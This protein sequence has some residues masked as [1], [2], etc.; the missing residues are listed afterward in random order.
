MHMM[1]IFSIDSHSV[2]VNAC[3]L[4]TSLRVGSFSVC[5][6]SYQSCNQFMHIWCLA[7]LSAHHHLYGNGC[8]TSALMVLHLNKF[9]ETMQV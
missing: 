8:K 9:I 7:T 2:I 5:L 4:L 1:N 6:P 3:T